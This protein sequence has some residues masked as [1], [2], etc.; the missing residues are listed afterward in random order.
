MTDLNLR[1]MVKN[2]ALA[3]SLSDA[4]IGMA[5]RML[6]EKYDKYRK[7][8]VR[9]DRSFPSPKM[10]SCCGHVVLVLPLQIREWKCAMCGAVHE[11]DRNVANSILAVGQTVTAQGDRLRD[12]QPMGCKSSV[13]E[14]RTILVH[15]RQ[16]PP[17]FREGRMS[18]VTSVLLYSRLGAPVLSDRGPAN[19]NPSSQDS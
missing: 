18:G 14:V 16:E 12:A 9:I 4:G 13:D 5:V 19:V 8:V 6:E 11:R 7:R 10:C 1:G 15:Q 3:R 17:P 2:H